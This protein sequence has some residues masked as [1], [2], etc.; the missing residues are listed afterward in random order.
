MR[1]KGKN[2]PLELTRAE[3]E[4]I[5]HIWR[6]GEAFLGEVV[7]QFVEPRPA[8]TTIST[9]IR[10][11]ETKG[12]V[13]HRVVGKS[14]RYSPAVSKEEYR[15]GFMKRVVSNFFNNSP[16]QVLSFLAESGSLTVEQYEELK[17][18]AKQI[19]ETDENK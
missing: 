19:V 16:G 14:H 17:R 6:L 15:A 8:Y 4:V 3:L 7:E 5:Q 10:T 1:Q 11:L 2:Q 9:V 12:F 13:K 18:I